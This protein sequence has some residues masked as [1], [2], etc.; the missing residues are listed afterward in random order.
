VGVGGAKGFF[1]QKAAALNA[2]A[3]MQEKDRQ[4]REE[5]RQ[6]NEEKKVSRAAFK[7]KA[8]LFQ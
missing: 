2:D 1:E 8:S 7:E 4:Y 3:Q 6:K 5:V